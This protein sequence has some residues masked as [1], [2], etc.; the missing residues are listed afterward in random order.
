[1]EKDMTAIENKITDIKA[2]IQAVKDNPKNGS[3][4]GKNVTLTYDEE[5]AFQQKRLDALE[6]I[7]NKTLEEIKDRI[8][9]CESN[10]SSEQLCC[11]YKSVKD[12]PMS[13]IDNIA[14]VE[15]LEDAIGELDK[16][17]GGWS[18]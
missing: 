11:K 1:M 10:L 17:E 5:L 14:E 15:L 8:L 4:I 13:A 3:T 12:M 9:V 18:T 16:H 7:K 6:A 2:Q